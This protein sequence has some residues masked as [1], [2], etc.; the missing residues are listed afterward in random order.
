M[1]LNS[2][3]MRQADAHSTVDV[4]FV[5]NRL[6]TQGTLEQASSFLRLKQLAHSASSWDEMADKRIKPNIASGKISTSDLFSLLAEVEEH[7]RQHIF[8]FQL[9]NNKSVS[10]LFNAPDLAKRIASANL[11]NLGVPS[12]VD[13][14]KGPTIV[15][16]RH[17]TKGKIQNLIVK[18]VEERFYSD[19]RRENSVNGQMVVTY[20]LHPYRAVHIIRIQENGAAEIR[21]Y[22]HRETM[23][24]QKTADTLWEIAAPVVD[25]RIFNPVRLDNFKDG[26]WNKRKR[27]GVQKHFSLRNSDHKNAMGN[28]IRVSAGPVGATMLSDAELVASVDRFHAKR[29]WVRCERASAILKS[30]ASS[31]QLSRDVN[32]LFHGAPNEFTITSKV[33]RSEYE[34]ILEKVLEANK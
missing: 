6:R 34:Y 19:N 10:C 21:V 13:D 8:L 15:E 20:D 30:E 3:N 33:T 26:L 9:A 23:D 18:I 32:L 12:I 17:D 25:N 22:S 29:N 11:P 1:D 28:R 24:Y 31:G 7:G 5:L 2:A 16:I 27:A 4:E 14:P